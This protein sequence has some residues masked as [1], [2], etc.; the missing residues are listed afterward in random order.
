M[1]NITIDNKPF[2]FRD[3][4]Q[5]AKFMMNN[6][7]HF[8][9]LNNKEM[10]KVKKLAKKYKI[11]VDQCLS[12]RSAYVKEHIIRNI[13]RIV[14]NI[15]QIKHKFKKCTILELSKKYRHPPVSLLKLIIATKV[16]NRK[17]LKE[18]LKSHSQFK[19]A[20]ENDIFTST[21][22]KEIQEKSELFERKLEKYLK[23]KNI[24]FKTQEQLVKE[25]IEKYGQ[26]INTPDFLI[27]SELKINGKE[28]KW[29]D[30]KNFYGAN[31]FLI[32][33]SKKQFKKYIDKWGYGAVVFSYGY[34]EK[35]SFKD[36]MLID[37]SSLH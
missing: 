5:I 32:R 11:S 14:S 33:K 31:T 10:D 6:F 19:I 7:R 24:K 34:G 16:D 15:N 8:N 17:E 37:Y 9:K 29:I 20:E 22:Q 1:T 12:I 2:S 26:P 4:K 21:D 3:E 36:T 13:D 23:S 28:I 35:L 30:A 25:Q 27:L 18:K